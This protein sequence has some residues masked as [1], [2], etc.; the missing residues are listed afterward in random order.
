M[1]RIAMPAAL[2]MV[3]VSAGAQTTPSAIV[4][5]WVNP[6]SGIYH[7]PG[8]VPYGK[9]TRGE[10]LPETVARERG[11]RPAGGRIC[12]PIP[13][14]DA[15]PTA[16]TGT[17]V[18]CTV[19]RIIDGDTIVCDPVGEIRLTGIDSPEGDQEPFGSQARAALGGLWGVEGFRCRPAD[20]RK[21]RC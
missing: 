15:V 1:I 20:H 12:G 9:T 2:L 14:L 8:T 7:C 3:A 19:S 13:E 10:L 16:P 5:V 17:G 6:R 11:F 21:R 4:P 18:S